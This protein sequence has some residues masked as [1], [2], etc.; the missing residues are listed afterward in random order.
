[1]SN[2]TVK[3]S[4][5]SSRR[6]KRPGAS[7]RATKRTRKPTDELARLAALSD[8]EIDT[9]DVPEIVNWRGAIRGRFYRPVKQLVTIRLDADVVAWFKS[10]NPTYQTAVNRALRDYMLDYLRGRKRNRRVGLGRTPG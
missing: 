6:A 7:E 5:A 10:R 4:S 3:K 8:A 9:S 1:M 2:R